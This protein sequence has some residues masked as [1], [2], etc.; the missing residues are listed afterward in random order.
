M[1][2]KA[3]QRRRT[4]HAQTDKQRLQA[5][6][7]TPLATRIRRNPTAAYAQMQLRAV[8]EIL[9]EGR[10]SAQAEEIGG[11]AGEALAWHVE[12]VLSRL[13]EGPACQAG[14]AWCCTIPVSVLPPEALLIARYLRDTLPPEALNRAT[15]H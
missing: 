4:R 11:N 15:R 9:S 10:T 1:S 6:D 12:Q 5:F 13:P 7:R 3:Q 2:K 8:L 14:C